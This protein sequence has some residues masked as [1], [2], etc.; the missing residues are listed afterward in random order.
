MMEGG[1]WFMTILDIDD[2]HETYLYDYFL[3]THAPFF[4]LF[5]MSLVL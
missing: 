5:F 3:A 2:A 1:K 4:L